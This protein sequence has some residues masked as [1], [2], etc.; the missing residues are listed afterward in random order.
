MM[1]LSILAGFVLL[2]VG[3]ELLVRGASRL[4]KAVGIPAL[5][6]G[7]TVVAFG[8]GAPEFAVSVQASALGQTDICVGNVVGS[9]ILNVL[10]ILGLSA[11]T[12][13]LATS[14]QLVRLDVPVMIA[15]SAA[16]WFLAADGEIG[17]PEGLA[18][19]SALALYTVLLV[20]LA[21]R[22][23]LGPASDDAAESSRTLPQLALSAISVAAGVAILV[24]GSRWLVQ[25]SVE[26]SR[27]LG[28]SELLIGLTIVSV[29]TSLPELATS[30]V[31][32]IRGEREIAIGNV[33]G[34]NIFNIL[35]V[36]GASAAVAGQG[37]EV[38]PSA[39]RFDIP[40]M[41]AVAVACLPVFFTGGRISRLEGM[42]LVAYYV[43]YV[44]FLVL[45]A[46]ASPRFTTFTNAM[47]FIVI[48]LTLIGVLFSI[49]AAIRQRRQ[50]GD[51]SQTTA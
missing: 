7:L 35:G 50:R 10:L 47:V 30:V 48:P 2:I 18:L 31:A 6:V 24:L 33:V 4:A 26:L 14:P 3:A 40:I 45:H 22:R 49:F 13:P 39:L 20:F 1:T 16:V 44:T 19:L 34:S 12:V 32:G 23:K 27:W 43:A 51:Q 41:T 29:G 38:N 46:T 8:T 11:L 42:I 25:G 21:K 5:I 15:A 36:L 9:N 17:R 28:V 37:M